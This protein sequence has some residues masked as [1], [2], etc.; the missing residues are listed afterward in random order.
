MDEKEA[1]D[2]ARQ[3]VRYLKQEMLP[4]EEAQ[5]LQLL[6]NDPSKR[7]L[8]AGYTQTATVQQ[9]LDGMRQLDPDRAWEKIRQRSRRSGRAIRLRRFISYA[10]VI[11]L[12]LSA[13]LW[14]MMWP[15]GDPGLVADVEHRYQNDVLPGSDQ[16]VLTL[17]DGRR[18]SLDKQD[19][20]LQEQDG[21]TLAGNDGELIYRAGSAGAGREVLY[22]TLTVPKSGMYRL[23]LPDGSRVW[24]NSLSEL[25]F[26]VQFSAQERR[27]F[28]KGEA[29]FE[30]ARDQ[31]RPFRVD[32][33]GHDIT[34]LGTSF[35]V[36]AYGNTA[37]ATLLEG[38]VRVSNGEQSHLLTPG[39]QASITDTQIGIRQADTEKVIAWK[40]G[41]FHFSEDP[42]QQI[43]EQLARWY[44]LEIDYQE[45]IP[46]SRFGGSISREVRLS[47]VLEM[48]KDVSGLNFDING[49]KLTVRSGRSSDK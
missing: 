45:P 29:F 39:K 23:M 21:T 41:Y 25:R 32:V 8:L 27:V 24:V 1:L 13:A 18:I 49:R 47:E 37:T 12:V 40:D 28:L 16:A 5:F 19:T 44:D 48:L 30:V 9:R 14:W 38:S 42:I 46:R 26:P 22:N 10:A 7:E 31:D 11:T 15:A 17:S 3:I 35:N 34:V 2:F 20:R 43:M 33:N 6:E 4:E 36:V